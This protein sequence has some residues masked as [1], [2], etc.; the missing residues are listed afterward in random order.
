V[1]KILERKSRGEDVR[2]WVPGCAT[3]EEAFSI[4]ILL[5]QA[6]GSRSLSTPVQIFATDIDAGAI[7]FARCGF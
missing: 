5:D 2:I 3:G 7:A 1:R 6:L 4:A